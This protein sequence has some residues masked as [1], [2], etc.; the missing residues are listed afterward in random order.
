MTLV[1]NSDAAA[2]LPDTVTSDA[3]CRAPSSPT[4]RK[5]FGSSMLK[6]AL[7]SSIQSC[8]S[9]RRELARMKTSEA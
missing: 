2:T 4:V 7:I 3:V 1:N 9:E 8:M 5:W 6:K